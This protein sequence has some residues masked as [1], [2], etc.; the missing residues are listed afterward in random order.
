MIYKP[1]CEIECC[2]KNAISDFQRLREDLDGWDKRMPIALCEQHSKDHIPVECKIL[3]INGILKIALKAKTG[4]KL[5]KIIIGKT[6]I[7]SRIKNK[8]A[9]LATVHRRL[10]KG[11]S[12]KESLKPTNYYQQVSAFK[13]G[14]FINNFDSIAECSRILKTPESNINNVLK[15]KRKTAGGY[16]FKYK[17]KKSIMKKLLIGFGV[18]LAFAGLG[19]TG[20]QLGNAGQ[21][22]TMAPNGQYY[23]WSDP[24]PAILFSTGVP[25]NTTGINGN[26]DIDNST[27]NVY[28]RI[29]NT[30]VLKGNIK[31]TP[32]PQGIQ[33]VAGIAGIAGSI[34]ATGLQGIQGPAG[35]SGTANLPSN[36]NNFDQLT[37]FNGQYV[38]LP[39]SPQ[40]QVEYRGLTSSTSLGFINTDQVW[41]NYNP[42][43]VIK[44]T[45]ITAGSSVALNFLYIDNNGVTVTYNFP[46]TTVGVTTLPLNKVITLTAGGSIQMFTT[47]IGTVTYDVKAT[48]N[49]AP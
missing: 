6:S 27:W 10:E 32:G 30:W 44:I 9:S 12:I 29:A 8:T 16:T 25:L 7:V 22:L 20:L 34:G 23:A 2:S 3:I 40:Y 13:D 11:L 46:V 42:A 1:I 41:T 21:L 24:T 45:S 39:G 18:L 38:L 26:V 47:V 4:F 48:I 37:W 31:G 19:M 33:G 17:Q 15:G 36:G 5:R 28:Y 43:G 49:Q 35:A 14:S